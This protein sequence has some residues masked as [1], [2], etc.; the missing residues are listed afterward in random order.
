MKEKIIAV[1]IVLLLYLVYENISLKKKIAD[2]YSEHYSTKIKI[3]HSK[4]QKL[5]N[6]VNAQRATNQESSYSSIK[7]SDIQNDH[8]RKI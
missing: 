5:R 1:V 6:Q 4:H 2:L 8:V 3:L 7:E